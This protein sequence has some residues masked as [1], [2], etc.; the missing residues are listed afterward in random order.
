MPW[1]IK[2][3][4]EHCPFIKARDIKDQNTKKFETH[5]IC[6]YPSGSICNKERCP[7]AIDDLDDCRRTE[8]VGRE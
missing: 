7:L 4:D 8:G 3:K 1:D 2:I 6:R 5:L